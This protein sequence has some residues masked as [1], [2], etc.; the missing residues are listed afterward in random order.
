MRLLGQF[1]ISQNYSMS[2]G[3]RRNK[4]GSKRTRRPPDVTEVEEKVTSM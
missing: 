2:S 1:D 3:K 4:D